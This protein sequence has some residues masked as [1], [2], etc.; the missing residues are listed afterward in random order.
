MIAELCILSLTTGVAA[1]TDI[2][3]R[4]IPN[5]LILLMLLCGFGM[6]LQTG[7]YAFL[8]RFIAATGLFIGLYFL[9]YTRGYLPG[10]DL[11]ALVAI[12]VLIGPSR[13]LEYLSYMTIPVIIVLL[14]YF[15]K[16]G[17]KTF[18]LGLPM[19]M[20]SITMLIVEVWRY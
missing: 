18:P 6:V 3:N 7:W 17:E 4:K 20:A 5:Y 13:Y 2:K 15:L 12:Y 19:A 11:K 9:G 16:K 1:I 8:V 14:Y 10:G